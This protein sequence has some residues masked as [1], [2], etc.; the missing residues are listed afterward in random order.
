LNGDGTVSPPDVPGIGAD[1]NYEA[2]AE[3]RVA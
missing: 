1:S 3:F 2:L